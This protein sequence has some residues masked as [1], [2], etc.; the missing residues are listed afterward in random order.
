MVNILEEVKEMSE[1]E[2]TKLVYAIQDRR[3][4]LRYDKLKEFKVGDKVKWVHGQ[5]MN[6]ENYEGEV[7]K[8][9]LKTVA[10]KVKGKPWCKWRIS[11]SM[12]TKIEGD[13][14]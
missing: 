4:V 6:K 9:N 3:D 8:V 14:S 13:E 11:P 5:G 2:L 1:E 7:Y 10:T 12:L